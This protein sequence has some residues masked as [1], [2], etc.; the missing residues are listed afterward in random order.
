MKNKRKYP[1]QS[2]DDKTKKKLAKLSKVV[3]PDKSIVREIKEKAAAVMES[4]KNNNIVDIIGH[5]ELTE[6]EYAASAA[7]QGVKR[8]SSQLLLRKRNFL[9]K[10]METMCL[11]KTC[12]KFGCSADFMKSSKSC[13]HCCTIRRH[14]LSQALPWPPSCP[15]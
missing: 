13:A 6:H 8:G 4:R 3:K 10:K 12:I 9:R 14:I 2:E 5:L 11:E 7:I 15:S 1:N